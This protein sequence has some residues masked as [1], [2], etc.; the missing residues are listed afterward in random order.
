MNPRFHMFLLYIYNLFS[1][2]NLRGELWIRHIACDRH[3]EDTGS[4][5]PH[6]VDVG[7][8]NNFLMRGTVC[9]IVCFGFHASE[10]Y[11]V[12]KFYK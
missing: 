4:I 7:L 12:H 5:V 8:S 6:F 2:V 10:W 9:R 11:D 1:N 3:Y